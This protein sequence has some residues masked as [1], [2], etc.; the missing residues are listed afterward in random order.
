MHSFSAGKPNPVTSSEARGVAAWLVE[1]TALTFEQIATFT[2]LA[3]IEVR[4]IAD[5]EFVPK[6]TLVDPVRQGWIDP[7]DLTDCQEHPDQSLARP[8]S[9]GSTALSQATSKSLADAPIY[10]ARLTRLP[11]LSY[12]RNA[13]HST[14]IT[15]Y[16]SAGSVCLA[17]GALQAKAEKLRTQGSVF[18]IEEMP[19]LA[20]QTE[21]AT[22]FLVE[23][24][25]GLHLKRLE[26]QVEG[27]LFSG[28]LLRAIAALPSNSI[29]CLQAEQ[30]II[31]PPLRESQPFNIL[32]SQPQGSGR[33]L[34]WSKAPIDIQNDIERFRTLERHLRD[35]DQI[36]AT[37]WRASA[38]LPAEARLHPSDIEYETIDGEHFV[39]WDE[40]ICPLPPI[41]PA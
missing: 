26:D 5:G 30:R 25:R 24:N 2:G 8:W 18:R 15:R 38:D 10:G 21:G 13:W 35:L 22:I 17:I 41:T 6:P 16:Y 27:A 32:R 28:R 34:G 37:V 33:N 31:P 19:A 3:K 23:V 40:A 20:L 12:G 1:K 7:E 39:R 11:F 9:W 29:V 36:T 4:L 14:W